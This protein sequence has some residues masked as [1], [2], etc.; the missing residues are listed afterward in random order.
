[1]FHWRYPLFSPSLVIPTG[2][3]I[4]AP[5][6]FAIGSSGKQF[7]EGVLTV[8]KAGGDNPLEYLIITMSDVIVTSLSTGGSGGEDR[9]TENVSLNFAKIEYQYT[10]QTKEGA[11]GAKPKMQW[12]IKKGKGSIS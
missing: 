3:K 2:R 5:V 9:M 1:M 6:N 12:D 10:V 8:R 7:K 4:P 11:A